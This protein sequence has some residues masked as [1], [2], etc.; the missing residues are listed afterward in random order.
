[1]NTVYEEI[2]RLKKELTELTNNLVAEKQRRRCGLNVGFLLP[3]GA[4]ERIR[5]TEAELEEKTTESENWKRLYEQEINRNIIL[6]ERVE[7]A[8]NRLKAIDNTMKLCAE[9]GADYAI[10]QSQ[11]GEE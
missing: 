10:K 11:E 6:R 5:R 1:M 4:A 9:Q 2:D 3:F 8:E 7:K